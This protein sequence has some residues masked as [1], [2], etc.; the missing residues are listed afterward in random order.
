ML[1]VK[2]K[3][4]Q[5]Q[6]LDYLKIL[7]IFHWKNNTAGIYKQATGSYIPSQSVGSP[8]IIIVIKGRIIGCEV[9]AKGGKQSPSQKEFQSNLEAAGGKYFLA[10]CLEDVI[11][12]LKNYGK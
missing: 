8:D 5:K 1:E 7:H 10:F 11:N 9:K 3:E 12:Y 6:I 2:E 4:I